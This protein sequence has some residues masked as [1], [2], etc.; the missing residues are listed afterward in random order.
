[1]LGANYNFLMVTEIISIV[2]IKLG[3]LTISFYLLSNKYCKGG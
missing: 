2:I 1:M 3:G